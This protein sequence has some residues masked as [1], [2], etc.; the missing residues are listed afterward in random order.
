MDAYEEI[1]ARMAVKYGAV[2]KASRKAIG[3]FMLSE[4]HAVNV[5][6]NNVAKLNY[7]PNLISI[8][9]MHQW[10]F[11]LNRRLSF[12]FVD[13]EVVDGDLKILKE[14]PLIPI[15]HISW[16]CLTIEAQGFGVIQKCRDLVVIPTQTKREFYNGFLVA[17]AKYRAKEQRKHEKF[18]GRFFNPDAIDW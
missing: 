10:V 16:A 8:N 3:D 2:G 5:K 9:K 11:E 13:Y 12:I 7:S 1:E 18:S 6:S 14:T 4:E 15:E 17:Y